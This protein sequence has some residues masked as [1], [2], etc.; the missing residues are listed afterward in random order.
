M[1]GN[2]KSIDWYGEAPCIRTDMGTQKSNRQYRWVRI[3][4]MNTV[5]PA[6]LQFVGGEVS[7]VSTLEGFSIPTD[8]KFVEEWGPRFTYEDHVEGMSLAEA[9]DFVAQKR[10]K[11]VDCPC[12]GRLV[13]LYKRKLHA[14]MAR[15]LTKLVN[16]YQREP[17][18]Y[19]T[20]ELLPH[21]AKAATDGSFLIHWGLIEK[22]QSKNKSGAKAG[23]YRP[24]TEG[25][26][27][28]QNRRAVA[29]HIFLLVNKFQG[30]SGSTTFIS[31]VEGFNF[32]ELM[33]AR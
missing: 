15:F 26:E 18:Y 13:K 8:P 21:A 31:D 32:Y 33:R 5:V 19:S 14:E 6:L 20:R 22:L 24:T 23:M 2:M 12:C 17:R 4:N 3:K 11:G 30:F 9:K 28:A 25:I 10:E 1:E 7:L 29:S 16:A 27:F